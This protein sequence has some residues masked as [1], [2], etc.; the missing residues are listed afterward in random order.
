MLVANLVLVQ[1]EKGLGY[2]R[3]ILL[4]SPLCYKPANRTPF[5]ASELRTSGITV[6]DEA[7]WHQRTLRDNHERRTLD[8]IRA[9]G[10]CSFKCLS[11]GIVLLIQTIALLALGKQHHLLIRHSGALATKSLHRGF[12][13]SCAVHV[14]H[15][16]GVLQTTPVS[17][18]EEQPR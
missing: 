15:R 8:T 2:K 5:E 11:W 4:S 9:H 13:P 17:P 7:C 14:C 1:V 3:R 18:L 16:S 10:C 12:Y 6:V